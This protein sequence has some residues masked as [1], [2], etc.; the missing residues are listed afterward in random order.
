[1][2][3]HHITDILLKASV[4]CMRWVCFIYNSLFVFTWIYIQYY[5]HSRPDMT[6]AVDWA[7]S[8][9]YLSIYYKHNYIFQFKKKVIICRLVGLMKSGDGHNSNEHALDSWNKNTKTCLQFMNRIT[10]AS[11]FFRFRCFQ[12]HIKK[13]VKYWVW[14]V[15]VLSPF[16]S[17][18]SFFDP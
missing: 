9:N 1:M 8:N 15:S 3:G 6:F 14:N 11:I 4:R 18:W 12:V 16:R 17:T 10:F 2:R 7:L 13:T 5:K